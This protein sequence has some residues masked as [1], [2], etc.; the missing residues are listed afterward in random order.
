[1]GAIVLVGIAVLAAAC[2]GSTAP[3]T[4][5]VAVVVHDRSADQ[6]T[7][8]PNRAEEIVSDYEYLL[9]VVERSGCTALLIAPTDELAKAAQDELDHH[10]RTFA[11]DTFA[12]PPVAAARASLRL[13]D[14]G[15]I[16]EMRLKSTT[17]E[18]PDYSAAGIGVGEP[19]TSSE[20]TRIEVTIVLRKPSGRVVWRKHVVAEPV[21][22]ETTEG[23]SYATVYADTDVPGALNRSGLH[24]AIR[25]A[26]VCSGP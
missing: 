5:D 2:G 10:Y 16:V 9:S 11:T 3:K 4:A 8:L 12:R 20:G 24:A 14:F 23:S 19:V 1:V 13:R 7:Y 25:G 18:G 22:P 21:F 26:R 6:Q 15:A 17:V